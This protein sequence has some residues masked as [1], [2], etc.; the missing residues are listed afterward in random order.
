MGIQL[1]LAVSFRQPVLLTEVDTCEMVALT[2]LVAS[3][4][5]LCLDSAWLGDG[6][7]PMRF[8]HA[9]HS[10]FQFSLVWVLW[11]RQLEVD[12]AALEQTIVND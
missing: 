12:L 3:Q 4:L 10:I 2:Y 9:L 11:D 8:G 7:F 5:L 1:L 6:R